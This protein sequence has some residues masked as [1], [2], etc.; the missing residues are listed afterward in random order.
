MNL[1]KNTKFLNAT[2]NAV[3]YVK[4]DRAKNF[5]NWIKLGGTRFFENPP[6]HPFQMY[7]DCFGR[8]EYS[9]SLVNSKKRVQLRKKVKKV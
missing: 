5:Q 7:L 4:F 1:K 6:I 2:N 3:P 9:S 8:E